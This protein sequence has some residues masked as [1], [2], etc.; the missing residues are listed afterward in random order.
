MISRCR[1]AATTL[2][3]S[4][5]DV[6]FFISHFLIAIHPVLSIITK[7]LFQLDKVKQL[8][9]ELEGLQVQ[10]AAANDLALKLF[11]LASKSDTDA[12]SAEKLVTF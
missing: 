12:I 9:V 7:S 4:I 10:R 3:N 2:R 1:F 5:I 6:P 8:G 11:K